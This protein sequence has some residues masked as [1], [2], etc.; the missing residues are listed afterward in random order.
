MSG[1]FER[2]PMDGPCFARVSGGRCGVLK[3]VPLDECHFQ[4]MYRTRTKGRWFQDGRGVDDVVFEPPVRSVERLKI[5]W[6]I[7]TNKILRECK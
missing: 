2:C 7:T 1:V 3:E 4:K 6:D 5:D